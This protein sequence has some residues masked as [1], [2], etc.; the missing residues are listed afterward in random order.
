MKLSKVDPELTSSKVGMKA[1]PAMT[2][3]TISS[4]DGIELSADVWNSAARPTLLLLA[5][6]AELRTVWHPVVEKLS[7]EIVSLWR[8][9]A[10]DHRGHGLSGRSEIYRFPQF[11]DDLQQWIAALKAG[12]LVIVGG[13]IGGALGMISAG[14][15]RNID[16]LV[17][18]DVPTVPTLEK[19]LNERSRIEKARA[20]DHLSVR[21]VDPRFIASGFIEE[22]FTDL[23]RWRRAAG[24]VCIPTLLIAGSKGVI[25]AEHIA[26]YRSHIPHGKLEELTTSHLVARDDPDGVAMLI[27]SFLATYF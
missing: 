9:V 12:P 14:E 15:K 10:V 16:G 23:D 21:D 19:V 1:L 24:Q 4:S 6:G 8:I 25:T 17:L 11:F 20:M 13:S 18:L 22:I 7:K 27:D 2:M 26:Q 3:M 5:C